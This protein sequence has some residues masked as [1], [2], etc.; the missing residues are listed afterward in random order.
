MSTNGKPLSGLLAAFILAVLIA[1]M[2]LAVRL[3][4]PGWNFIG[5]MLLMLIF[6]I[7]IG[8][9]ITGRPAGIL[10]NERNLM[11]L[12]RLQLVLWTLV[13]LSA[14]LTIALERIRVRSIADALAIAL[15]QRLWALMGISTASL[16]GSPLIQT[17][18]K[19]QDPKPEAVE[20]ASAALNESTDEINKNSQGL[21][22]SNGGIKDAAFSD[23]FE[24]DEVGN[25]AYVDVAKV[26]M[27]F[28]TMVAALSYGTELFYWIASKPAADLTAFPILSGGLV[29]ILGISH[30]G[31]LVNNST[32]HTPTK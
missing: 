18:K 6:M 31:F 7:T 10:I 24:G 28:F 14:Y 27:F 25:T 20:K 30:A 9:T 4:P 3:V 2:F 23:M 26:Q 5:V 11:S 22:Y 16:I 17:T 13:I 19:L 32:T 29:A 1:A 12:S 8:I 21:L 15:D